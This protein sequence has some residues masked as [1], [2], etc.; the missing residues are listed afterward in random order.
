MICALIYCASLCMIFVY[1]YFPKN[2]D[3]AEIDRFLLKI[4]MKILFWDAS[5]QPMIFSLPSSHPS[6]LST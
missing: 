5:L 2:L 1:V 4:N 3:G 6:L